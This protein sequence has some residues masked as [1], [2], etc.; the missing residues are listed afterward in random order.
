MIAERMN[1]SN[2]IQ[3]DIIETV[4]ND[5]KIAE[6]EENLRLTQ[7]QGE[8][9]EV[10]E[11][12]IKDSLLVRRGANTDILK[13][14]NE[15]KALIVEGYT[16]HLQHYV[17]KILTQEDKPKDPEKAK[18]ALKEYLESKDNR[19]VNREF[20]SSINTSDHLADKFKVIYPTNPY[21]SPEVKKLFL[22]LAA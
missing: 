3:S 1:I 22:G 12:Y 11:R 7:K 5:L 14:F 9:K 17:K 13:A 4:M 18:K 19:K 21:L 20:V 8:D 2:V 6:F 15:G 10:I 16:V